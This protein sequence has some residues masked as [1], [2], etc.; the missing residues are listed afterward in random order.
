[1]T[2]QPMDP[3]SKAEGDGAQESWVCAQCGSWIKPP[4]WK[5]CLRP[6][7]IPGRC[8]RQ[9]TTQSI[10]DNLLASLLLTLM[11]CTGVAMWYLSEGVDSQR[12]VRQVWQEFRIDQYQQK[13][14]AFSQFADGIPRNATYLI[15]MRYM[16]LWINGVIADGTNPRPAYYNGRSFAQVVDALEEERRLWLQHCPHYTSLCEAVRSQYSEHVGALADIV[17]RSFDTLN[18]IGMNRQSQIDASET[19]LTRARDLE[20]RM[21][22]AQAAATGVVDPNQLQIVR[23]IITDLQVTHD[24]L[25]NEK[26]SPRDA[27]RKLIQSC[28]DTVDQSYLLAVR[29]MGEELHTLPVVDSGGWWP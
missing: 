26:T 28:M 3:T 18:D 24:G 10:T 15:N 19:M 25:K 22:A 21:A 20:A 6:W 12:A 14:Q 5:L 23:G 4:L 29:L 2:N 7:E 16:T 27:A 9:I 11:A 13:R 1:M 8:W 17:R